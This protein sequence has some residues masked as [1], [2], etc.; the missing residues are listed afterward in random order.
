MIKV[1]WTDISLAEWATNPPREIGLQTQTFAGSD[2]HLAI[3]QANPENSESQS[4]NSIPQIIHQVQPPFS[5]DTQLHE[6]N[7]I[8]YIVPVKVEGL[9]GLPRGSINPLK[10]VLS[11]RTRYR[12]VWTSKAKHCHALGV[13][14]TGAPIK[15]GSLLTIH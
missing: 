4:G 8:C 6:S 3:Q 11:Y 2:L 10:F 15:R 12:S 5:L 7:I 9:S 1:S 14:G 13:E